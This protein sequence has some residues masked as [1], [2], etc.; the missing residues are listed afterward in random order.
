MSALLRSV[1][2]RLRSP[3]APRVLTVPMLVRIADEERPGTSR[4]AV[5]LIAKALDEDGDIRKVSRG[6][7][8]NRCLAE[9]TPIAEAAS[10]IRKGAIVSLHTVLGDA[11]VLNNYTHDVWSVIPLSA[12]STT[13]QRHAETTDRTSFFFRGIHR[14]RLFAPSREDLFADVPYQRAT[15]EAALC[16]WVYLW[17]SPWSAIGKLPGDLDLETFDME[18]ATRIADAMGISMAFQEWADSADFDYEQDVAPG[19]GF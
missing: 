4:A 1:R 15:I 18:R 14:D 16:H 10:F 5:T 13:S 9:P 3:D 11:G 6:L 17:K 8:L 2:K 12:E 19:L 7:Y